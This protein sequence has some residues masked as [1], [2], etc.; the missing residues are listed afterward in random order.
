MVSR[1]PL[2]LLSN[3]EANRAEWKKLRIGKM[4]ASAAA[5]V[6][7]FSDRR[8]PLETWLKMTGR[9][10]DPDGDNQRMMAGRFLEPSIAQWW[11][12]MTESEIEPSPGL[13]ADPD[14]PWL[15]GTPDFGIKPNSARPDFGVLEVK[16]VDTS[17]RDVWMTSPPNG[18]Y[19]QLQLYLHLWQREHGAF[20]VCFG[21]NDLRSF[22]QY[23]NDAFLAQLLP[24][25]ERWYQRHI[26]EGIEP[27]VT[28]TEGSMQ[29]FKLLHPKDNG[30][31]VELS[32]DDDVRLAVRWNEISD[33]M[34][35]L[36]E[37]EAKI[38]AYFAARIVDATYGVFPQTLTY[39]NGEKK[40]RVGAIK[41]AHQQI[42][43]KPKE[44]YVE[45]RRVM[46][47]VVSAK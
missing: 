37:E 7:G 27:A 46:T 44:A 4:S 40:K 42:N 24:A 47:R 16:N 19:I 30:E 35:L 28:G 20:A 45:D 15:I 22:V 23:R 38:K 26:V 36:E 12:A 5:E 8:S 10:P 39:G 33:Q 6:L 32:D 25:L 11:A 31:R 14:R 9:D 34:A 41:F 3:P 13:I 1:P 43:H 21:G 29:A 2:V 18:Y 17:F